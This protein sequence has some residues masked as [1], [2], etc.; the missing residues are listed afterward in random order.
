MISFTQGDTAILNLTATDGSGNPFDITAAVFTSY[1]K[2]SNG[3]I[4]TFPNAQ[5][6]IVT[7]ASGTYTL[8]LSTADTANCGLGMNKEILTQIVQGGSTIFFRGINILTVNPP[9]PLQ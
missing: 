5:H 8:T 4:V 6:A 1:I 2:G 9:V 7:A 3:V